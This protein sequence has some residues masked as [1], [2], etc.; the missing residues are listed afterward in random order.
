M[1]KKIIYML[2]IVLSFSVF[3]QEQAV[4]NSSTKSAGINLPDI[5]L[6]GNMIGFSST[7]KNALDNNTVFID[8]IEL[9]IQGYV[10]PEIKADV[11][12]SF[13]RG[14]G[15]FQGAVEEADLI[16]QRVAEGLSLKTGKFHL[17]FGK[18]NRVHSHEWAY[19]DQPMVLNNFFGADGLTGEGGN[20]SYLLPL[21]F[22]LQIDF[23]AWRMLADPNQVPDDF[24]MANIV[25]SSRLYTSFA[26]TD[27]SELE[28]GLSVVSGDGSH[29]N[30]FQDDAK[31]YGL[32]L[33]YLLWPASGQRFI[34]QSEFLNLDRTLPT[35]ELQRYG[36]YSYAG[37]QPDKYWEF[38]ARYD[39]SDNPIPDNERKSAISLILTD[40]ITEMTKLRVQYEYN[41]ES[42]VH[43]VFI[44]AVFGMGPHTHPLN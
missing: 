41:M 29:Y 39:L 2:I 18:I 7:D 30:E 24:S 28:F 20:L 8:E 44:Q 26:L 15:S 1:H 32:D 12:I 31:I 5:S 9:G 37:Y 42:G 4:N 23:G 34:F 33:T 22:F 17:D 21:P 43:E 38:G 40:K 3:A 35:G 11:F 36:F 27:D 14:D 10:A 6:V 19:V 16:F 25:L 13:D